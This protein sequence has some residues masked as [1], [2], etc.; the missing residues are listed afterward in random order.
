MMHRVH[1]WCGNQLHRMSELTYGF[2]LPTDGCTSY[3]LTILR[4]KDFVDALYEHIHLENNILFQKAV[5]LE[6]EWVCVR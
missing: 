5:E 6:R 3:Q 1:K 4:L 2:A